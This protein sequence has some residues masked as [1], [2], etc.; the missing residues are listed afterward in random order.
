MPTSFFPSSTYTGWVTFDVVNGGNVVMLRP[1]GT[2]GWIFTLPSAPVV[3]VPT[4]VTTPPV[5]TEADVPDEES[6]IDPVAEAARPAPATT[7]DDNI[8]E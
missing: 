2:A 4:T 7:T 6:S 1:S 5:T 3:S 8:D